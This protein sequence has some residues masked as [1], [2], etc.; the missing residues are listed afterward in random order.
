[1]FLSK[2]QIPKENIHRVHGEDNPADERVRYSQT[3][4]ETVGDNEGGTPAFDVM[5]L[6]LGEDGH[7]ASIFPNQI[8]ILYS[9]RVCEIA[10]HPETDQ[11]RITVTGRIINA[12]RHVFFLVTG[13]GKA[14]VLAE[15]MSQTGNYDSYP[16]SH[17]SPAS[18]STFYLDQAAASKL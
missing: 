15:I 17:L 13:A 8:E 11:K 1:L 14:D 6:G 10:T 4:I 16:A 7:T 3:I 2:I 9:D 12:S 5:L 18:G